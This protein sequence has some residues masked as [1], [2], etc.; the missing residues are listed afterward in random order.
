MTNMYKKVLSA[1]NMGGENNFIILDRSQVFLKTFKQEYKNIDLKKNKYC[2]VRG[3]IFDKKSLRTLIETSKIYMMQKVVLMRTKGIWLFI[4][5]SE[6]NKGFKSKK[7]N[8]YHGKKPYK[9]KKTNNSNRIRD[10]SY[11]IENNHYYVNN[12]YVNG[13]KRN[14]NN[15]NNYKNK[16]NANRNNSNSNYTNSYVDK[17]NE[18]SSKN[19]GE[20]SSNMWDLLTYVYGKNK[21]RDMD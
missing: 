13:G 8:C 18:S 11:V 7:N 10:D 2:T 9:K 4:S 15:N 17:N 1:I 14:N 19:N 12:N 3:K 21:V 16:K 20:Q 5:F 6:T